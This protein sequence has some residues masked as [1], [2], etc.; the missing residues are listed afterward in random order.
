MIRLTPRL[1]QKSELPRPALIAP[2]TSRMNALSTI[3][4]TEIDAVSDAN[5]TESA[6][7]N[8][9]PARSTGPIVSEEPNKNAK[10][11]ASTI[12]SSLPQPH[13][14]ARIMRGLHQSHSRGAIHGRAERG[15]RPLVAG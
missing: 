5:A 13:Q 1:H 15:H 3:S 6:R 7:R 10:A 2:G 14:V 4:I 8:G 12:D 9:T 11:M